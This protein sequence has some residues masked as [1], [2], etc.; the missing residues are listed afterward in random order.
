MKL[1]SDGLG[2]VLVPILTKLPRSRPAF[3]LARSQVLVGLEL[4]QAPHVGS[5]S[6]WFPPPV[7]NKT[8]VQP[9][10]TPLPFFLVGIPFRPIPVGGKSLHRLF[11]F[12]DVLVW[13]FR[14][15][16]H[17]KSLPWHSREGGLMVKVYS[18]LK[19]RMVSFSACFLKSRS[20]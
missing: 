1:I 5:Q 8:L 11:F 17:R 20:K 19:Y 10:I 13:I 6:C 16:Q 14:L 15:F 9:H 7:S 18:C 3:R 4:H 12:S 2:S